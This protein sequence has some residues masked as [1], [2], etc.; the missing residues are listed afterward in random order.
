MLASTMKTEFIWYNPADKEYQFGDKEEYLEILKNSNQSQNFIILDT[1]SDIST[2][3][4][5]KLLNKLRFL[6]SVRKADIMEM[7]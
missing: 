2:S 1:F 3:F 6:N 7:I 5:E 4:R